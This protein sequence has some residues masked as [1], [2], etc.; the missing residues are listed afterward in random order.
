MVLDVLSK[1]E[2]A[3]GEIEAGAISD[4]ASIQKTRNMK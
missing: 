3:K 4:S 2:Q 1:Q